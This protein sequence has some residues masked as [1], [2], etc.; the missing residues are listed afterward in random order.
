[1]RALLALI[2]RGRAQ[3]IT[4]SALCAVL[5]LLFPPLSYAS[6]AIVGL[7]TLRQGAREG[8]LV[9]GGSLLLAGVFALLVAGTPAPALAFVAMSWLPA[10]L[11]A[12]VLVATRSQGAALL[13]CA[14]LGVVAVLALHV[15][16]ADPATWWREALASFFA[17]AL[18]SAGRETAAGLAELLDLWAPRM[19]R[20]F[21]A[22]V[23]AGAM[24]SLLL[25]RWGHAVLDNPGGFGEEFRALDAG[26]TALGVCLVVGVVAAFAGGG[27]GALAGDLM[28]PLTVVLLFQG[29]AVAHAVVRRRK[30]PGG[31]LVAMYLLLLVPPHL[32]LPALAGAGLLD[33]WLGF[34]VRAGTS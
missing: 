13:S 32:A 6:G 27:L 25:A 8:A 34:R 9:V 24:L 2:M 30:L 1:V 31:W 15:A 10:W 4:A 11:I 23:A 14:G 28:G 26:R 18:E 19:T 17:P 21:G 29:L 7:A 5:S 22:A 33:G 16:V 12:V 20:Y 3:A